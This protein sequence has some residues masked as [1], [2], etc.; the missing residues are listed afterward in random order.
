MQQLELAREV[1]VGLAGRA[2]GDEPQLAAARAHDGARA[3]AQAAQAAAP[4][5]DVA[6]SEHTAVASPTCRRG[7]KRQRAR[8]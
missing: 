1:R 2:D 8:A 6:T 5:A 4:R 3:R 7:G